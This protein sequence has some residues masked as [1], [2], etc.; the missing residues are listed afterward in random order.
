MACEKFRAKSFNSKVLKKRATFIAKNKSNISNKSKK[1]ANIFKKIVVFAVAVFIV[2]GACAY[3]LKSGILK[4]FTNVNELR[5]KIEKFGFFA[6]PA[7]LLLQILQVAVFPIPGVIAIGVGVALFGEFKGGLYS[8]IG[9]T[10][11]SLIAFFIGRV[12]GYK[13]ASFFVGEKKLTALIKKLDGKDKAVITAMFFLP[14]F[15]DDLLCFV[16]GLSSMSAGYF[17]VVIIITRLTSSFLTAYSLG[18]KILPYNTWWGILL[19]AILIIGAFF[20]AKIIFDNGKSIEKN[21]AK[22]KELWA[23]FTKKPKTRK[24]GQAKSNLK[25]RQAKLLRKKRIKNAE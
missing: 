17:C 2:V 6:L 13:A 25:I 22:I 24:N 21:L 8:F 7:F 12:L 18:G 1:D 20:A 10:L 5:K 3:F 14:F 4:K 16:A 19:W 23:K 9:I 15:P 11:G